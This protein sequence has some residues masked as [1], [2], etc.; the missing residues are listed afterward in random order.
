ML[1]AWKS[2]QKSKRA[3]SIPKKYA[4]KWTIETKLIAVMKKKRKQVKVIFV[5]TED[6]IIFSSTDMRLPFI[7]LKDALVRTI[8]DSNI[9]GVIDPAEIVEPEL[10]P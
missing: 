4:Y 7:F 1:I 3:L 8:P 2:N 9:I 6:R 5:S 10:P